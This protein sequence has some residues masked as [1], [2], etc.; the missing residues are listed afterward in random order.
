MVLPPAR[1]IGMTEQGVLGIHLRPTRLDASRAR[2]LQSS[3]GAASWVRVERRHSSDDRAGCAQHQQIPG[4][5]PNCVYRCGRTR[6]SR[7][8]GGDDVGRPVRCAGS[9]RALCLP[10]VATR[11]RALDQRSRRGGDGGREI[12]L[13]PG[14]TI[15][16]AGRRQRLVASRKY[17]RRSG[18]SKPGNMTSG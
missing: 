12:W 13:S 14:Q 1:R 2:S 6:G 18:M 8:T 5:S 10:G 17:Q 15:G 4:R 16:R 11:G 7:T 9:G 3:S